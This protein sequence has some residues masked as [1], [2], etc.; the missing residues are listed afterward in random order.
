M[1]YVWSASLALLDR[2]STEGALD[3]HVRIPLDVETERPPEVG[4]REVRR[5]DPPKPI[6]LNPEAVT[7]ESAANA[8]AQAEAFTSSFEFLAKVLGPVPAP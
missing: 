3:Q 8:R 2:P 7:M 1:P 6:L 4:V 5:P